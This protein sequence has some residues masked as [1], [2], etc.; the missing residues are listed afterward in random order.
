[1]IDCTTGTGLRWRGGTPTAEREPTGR[2]TQ[3]GR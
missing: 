2:I 3:K 1:M